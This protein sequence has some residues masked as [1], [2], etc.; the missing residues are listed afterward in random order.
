MDDFARLLF[1]EL[2][3]LVPADREKLF[4]QRQ[5][6]PELRAELESLL[7]FDSEDAASL[8]DC[9]S[10]TAEQMLRSGDARQLNDCG[11][12][13]LI[14][15][16]GSGGMGAV[17]LAE[18]SDG[19]IQQQVAI[20]VLRAGADRPAWRD[21]FLKERQLLANLNHP[22][23]A[24]V[25]DAGH[26]ADGQPYL[27]ME[28]VDGL[29]IDLYADG[30]DLR[31]KLTLFLRVCDGVSHAHRHLI[32][33]RDL[34]PSNILVDASG[35]PKLL[36]FGIA[37][38]LDET[39]DATQTVE[40]MLTPNYASPEQI[41]GGNQSTA[42]DVYSLGAVLYKLLTDQSP[43]ETEPQPSGSGLRDIPPPSRLNPTLPSDIDYILRKAL[44]HEP[45]ERY[46][47]VEAFANDVRA[48]L[49]WRPVQARSGDVWYR[50]RRF[51]RRY[52]LP[53]T[54]ATVTL[55]SLSLGLYA[56]NRARAI[57]QRR[58][59]Q[60]RQLANKVLAL[61]G[62]IRVLPGS[63][64]AR[65]EIVAISKEYLEALGADAHADK[66]L[67][68]EIG[69]AYAHLA[70]VQG[71]PTS[72]NLG[73]YAQAEES[74]RK[75]DALLEPVLAASPQNR[76]ALLISANVAHERMILASSGHRNDEAL[77]QARKA[78][79]R[80]DAL[81][82]RGKAA[83][84]E[85]STAVQLFTN[86]ALAHKNMHLYDDAIRYARRSIEISRSLPSAQEA[87]SNALSV[88]ADSMRFSGD[89][90]GAL[91]AIREA[92]SNME[93]ADFHGE[94]S[95]RSSL[96]NV[97]WRE[98]VILG[99]DGGVNLDQP[100]EAIAVLQRAF[101]LTEEWAR[102]DPNDASCRILVASAGRELGAILRHRNPQRA[103]AVYDVGL[104]RLG[105][106]KNNVKARR[107]EA[108]MLAGSA[109][110]LR[111]LNRIS[112]AKNRIDSAFRLLRETKD[113]PADRINP[114]NEAA[115]ALRAL[116]DH[117]G[118][119]G[120]PQRAADVYQEL[121]DKIM[122]WKPDPLLD[123]RQATEL[124]RIYEALAALH[125]RNGHPDR[126]EAMSA[127]RLELWRQ[128]DRK[129][130]SNSFIRRQ[131]EAAQPSVT[132]RD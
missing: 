21:R 107:D 77:A 56:A 85:M 28:Y 120:Q 103:L 52:W 48:F 74:L 100:G 79:G 7:S 113:Y 41:S 96:F 87:L 116:G 121:L 14:R 122:A 114:D 10:D 6:G 32:V 73:Q 36:D 40:R 35:Q 89:L 124:S 60:V 15:L 92:R 68:L 17:Y 109:Y 25:I 115:A 131:L 44:R 83:Q 65:H 118:E 33:H 117:L 86:I 23:I 132:R 78:A 45:E 51:L 39:G 95:R 38:M 110:A 43:H 50:T 69:A 16:L 72:A 90:E 119:T 42:T 31:D 82:G 30:K 49:D 47:S 66:D 123:L 99:Q 61:D 88:L 101:D 34:K 59:L 12:Y 37:K 22:S 20:K 11:P 106:I 70:R 55:A 104:L 19:E 94:T 125:R 127:L 84:S 67:A 97:L 108:Q 98:G 128:W 80:L 105:E 58:F 3:D 130:P 53:V 91:Q 62:T 63:T 129:L 8:T 54:A 46:A 5:I 93:R 18:R 102:K 13:R 9:V 71:V 111:R 24:R 4:A 81:L 76:K 2:A 1:H 29:P 126:A 75:A 64:K 112:E 26:A 57:A 27:V